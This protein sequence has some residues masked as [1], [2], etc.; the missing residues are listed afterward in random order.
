MPVTVRAPLPEL[1]SELP[2]NSTPAELLVPLVELE[3]PVMPRSP[4]LIETELPESNATPALL[5]EVPEIDVLPANVRAALAKI[6]TPAELLLLPTSDRTFF[7]PQN[8][9]EF[10]IVSHS[11]GAVS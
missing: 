2:V 1:V 11:T 9:V 10:S 5:L 6:S 3:S 4:E 8:Y 7:A